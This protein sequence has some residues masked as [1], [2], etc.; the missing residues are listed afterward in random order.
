MFC[1]KCQIEIEPMLDQWKNK[2]CPNCRQMFT[3]P[4]SSPDDSGDKDSSGKTQN[5]E[6][7][8]PGYTDFLK[9][10]DKFR[11]RKHAPKKKN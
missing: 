6:S 3:A 10:T 9:S 5:Q 4:S 7:V 2:R 11:N 1:N 8:S